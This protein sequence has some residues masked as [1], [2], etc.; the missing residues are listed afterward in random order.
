MKGKVR[1]LVICSILAVALSV[2]SIL[3]QSNLTISIPK[4][5]VY[6]AV[7]RLNVGDV[8]KDSD[9]K[10]A[11]VEIIMTTPD[12]ATDK[13]QVVGKAVKQTIYAGESINVNRL[14]EKSDPNY[15]VGSADARRFSIPTSYIDDPYSL[16]FRQGDVVD[17][18]FVPS[19]KNGNMAVAPQAQVVMKHVMVVGA[20]DQNGAMLAKGSNTLATAIIFESDSANAL[21]ITADQYAGKFK[22]VKYPLNQ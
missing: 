16:T 20:I 12:M 22:F 8:V 11:S 18:I 1:L 2:A 15:F 6:Q 17:I 5:V 10:S 21:T 19:N 3:I 4:R 9:I 14:T 7:N 13:S